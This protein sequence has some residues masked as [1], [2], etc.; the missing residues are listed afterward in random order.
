MSK[1]I[2]LVSI[3]GILFV[4]AIVVG[5]L[6]MNQKGFFSEP[7]KNVTQIELFINSED[8]ETRQTLDSNYILTYNDSIISQGQLKADSFVPITLDADKLYT[9]SC[10][11]DNHYLVKASKVFS[12]EDINQKKARFTCSMVKIG[13][14]EVTTNN[15]LKIGTNEI[16]YKVKS[17]DGWTYRLS[18]CFSWSAGIIDISML[19]NTVTC[20]NAVWLNWSSYNGTTKTY[21]YLPSGQFR[22]G[23]RIENC[24][25]VESNRCRLAGMEIP[26]RF[27][28]KAD[29]CIYLGKT[30]APNEEYNFTVQVKTLD[31]LNQLDFLDLT[32]FDLDRRYSTTENNFV[33]V[34]EENGVDISQEDKIISLEYK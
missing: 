17:K 6:V 10:W 27:K 4:V 2:I 3:I 31:I 13:N 1:A 18:G 21:N 9:V 15:E 12:Q 24:E 30:L 32:M 7:E 34:D 25:K 11:N 5:V 16:M 28:D 23:D 8:I 33:W 19:S 20:E 29:S 22:C 26:K 14:L